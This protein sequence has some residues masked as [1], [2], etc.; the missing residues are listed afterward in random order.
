MSGEGLNGRPRA[1]VLDRIEADSATVQRPDGRRI[2]V[3]L[4][5]DGATIMALSVEG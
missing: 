1:F 3:A 2:D 4:A 5:R